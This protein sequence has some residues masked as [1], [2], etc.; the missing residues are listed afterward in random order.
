MNFQ[1]ILPGEWQDELEVI[2]SRSTGFDHLVEYQAVTINL[3]E[4]VQGVSP[5]IQFDIIV[6]TDRNSECRYSGS[7]FDNFV[8][9]RKIKI[10]MVC[11]VPHMVTAAIVCVQ[12]V[13]CYS[14]CLC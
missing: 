3:D 1:D 2:I 11:V 7:S 8:D 4:P 12:A 9:I 13:L 10:K 14:I 6:S 5:T